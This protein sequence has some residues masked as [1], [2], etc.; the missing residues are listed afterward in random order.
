MVSEL[1]DGWSRACEASPNMEVPAKTFAEH[2]AGK[3]TQGRITPRELS[4]LCFDDLYLAFGCLCEDPAALAKFETSIIAR[5]KPAIVRGNTE[6]AEV[7]DVLQTLRARLFVGEA[8]IAAYNGLGRLYSWTRIAALRILQNRRRS[9][10]REVSVDSEALWERLL[11]ASN[12]ELDHLKERYRQEFRVALALAVDEL[13]ERDRMLLKQHFLDG[14]PS[15]KLAALHQVHRATVSRWIVTAQQSL[16]DATR[17]QLMD[18]LAIGEG[19][20]ESVLRL[21]Q[22]RFETGIG[23]LLS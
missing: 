14:L 20:L 16:L 18:R 15:G 5:V 2:L 21:I 8:K 10:G 23:D 19:E 22:S 3:L 6:L 4:N 12:A 7:D 17:A 13:A 1:E 11:P 9:V